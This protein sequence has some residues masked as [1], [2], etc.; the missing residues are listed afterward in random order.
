MATPKPA[1]PAPAVVPDATATNPDVIAAKAAAIPSADANGQL[2][3]SGAIVAVMGVIA[4]ALIIAAGI[5]RDWSIAGLAIGTI[6]GA[7]A[8]ALNAPTGITS[9]LRASAAAKPDA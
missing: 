4:L 7:L 6:I 1:D 5:T 8:T 2:I 9:A 3:V